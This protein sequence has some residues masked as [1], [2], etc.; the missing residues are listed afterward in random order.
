MNVRRRILP[1]LLGCAAAATLSCG[2]PTA[3]TVSPARGAALLSGL[4]SC[5]PLAADSVTQVVGASGGTI[6]IGPH[7]LSI[8]AGA[9]DSNV[10][11]TATI[12]SETV[13]RV[14]FAPDGLQFGESASLTMSYANCGLLGRLLPKRIAHVTEELSILSFLWSVTNIFAQTVTADLEHFSDYAVA[15]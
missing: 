4:L 8:P 7:T 15:W 12:A 5:A 2:D 11:I 9:L 6:E 3:N 14:R 1:L 10:A 13:N